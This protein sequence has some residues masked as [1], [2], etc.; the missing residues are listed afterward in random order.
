MTI[1]AQTSY[2]H[3]IVKRSPK[4]IPPGSAEFISIK[5]LKGFN[6]YSISDIRVTSSSQVIFESVE[7]IDG[8]PRTVETR[9]LSEDEI[10][11][12]GGIV[13]RH[14]FQMKEITYRWYNDTASE[15][16]SHEI[17]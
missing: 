16:A 12:N 4:I 13:A 17:D 14:I 8:L 7:I 2:L 5:R 11:Q 1:E 10:N 6:N 15:N 3:N 9:L